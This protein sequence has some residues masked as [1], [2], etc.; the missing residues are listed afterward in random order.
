MPKSNKDSLQISSRERAL[1]WLWF[2]LELFV[3]PTFLQLINE[4]LPTPVS[5]AVL[6]FLFFCLNFLAVVIIFYRH[7][8]D[9][10]VSA[11]K[12][13]W[14]FIF[15]TV[16]GFILYWLCTALLSCLILLL[17]PDFLNVN[18]AGIAA[19]FQT[20]AALIA[21][22]TVLL[23]PVAEECLFRGLLFLDLRSRNRYLAYGISTVCFCLVHV[24]G[25]FGQMDLLTL[26]LCILQYVPA[27]ICLAWACEKSGS[28][29]SSILIHTAINAIG[30]SALR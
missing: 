13:F 14:H 4:Q 6:N 3:L 7:L 21:I 15:C 19:M 12:Q 27:G 16:L 28:I 30:I 5:D 25:H 10:L 23:V 11:G 8:L 29:F 17:D 20:H 2:L 26:L 22:G 9:A 24:S 1:G 18:D